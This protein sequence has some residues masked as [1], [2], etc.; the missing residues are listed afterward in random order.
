VTTIAKLLKP[1]C[2]N[3]VMTYAKN[4]DRGLETDYTIQKALE[5]AGQS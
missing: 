5:L 2:P 3:L 1:S 4:K